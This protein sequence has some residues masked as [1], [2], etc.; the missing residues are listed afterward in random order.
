MRSAKLYFQDQFW[1]ELGFNDPPLGINTYEGHVW[2]V[3][4]DGKVVKT[5]QISEKRGLDQ[6]F[7]I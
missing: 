5:W 6:E 3:M 1:G 7:S 4:V 2:N